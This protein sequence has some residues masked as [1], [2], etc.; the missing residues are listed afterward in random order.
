[1][2]TEQLGSKKDPLDALHASR[3]RRGGVF[4][5]RVAG[6]TSAWG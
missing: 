2:M 1:M 6:R 5:V 4:F 3:L